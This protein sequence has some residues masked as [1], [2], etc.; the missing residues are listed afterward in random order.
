MQREHLPLSSTYL[1]NNARMDETYIEVKGDQYYLYRAVDKLGDTI[2]F[3][4]SEKRDELS[5]KA[6][7]DKAIKLH[8]IPEKVTMDK[9]GA[10]KSRITEVDFLLIFFYLL[11]SSLIQIIVQ[12][13]KYLNDI[14][15]QDHR[16][17][18]IIKNLMLE[19][20]SF[21]SAEATLAGI[22]LHHILREKQHMN[23]ANQSIFAK[24][25]ALAG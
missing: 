2:D 17:I 23:A 5:A 15:E 8:D 16:S 18:K 22:E 10:N 21:H 9:S 7:F 4:L 3:M 12:Q 6:F 19:F 25:Y 11:G 13:I 24:F 1:Y 20:K 14:V